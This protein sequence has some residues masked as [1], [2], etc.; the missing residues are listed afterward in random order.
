M[1]L[2]V[3]NTRMKKVVLSTAQFVGR[4]TY[5]MS[6]QFFMS[7]YVDPATPIVSFHIKNILILNTLIYLG[8]II[9]IM[10]KYCMEQLQLY[11]IHPTPTVLELTN[12]SKI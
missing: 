2:C 7:K 12:R 10:T 9:N 6:R 8:D 5:V 3:K 4:S 1:E 11:N